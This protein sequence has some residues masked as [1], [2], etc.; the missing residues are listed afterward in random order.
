MNTSRQNVKKVVA[1]MTRGVTVG[2]RLS[3]PAMLAKK[4]AEELSII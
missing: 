3:Y 4:L 1:K 2:F